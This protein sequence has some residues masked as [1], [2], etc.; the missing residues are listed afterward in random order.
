MRNRSPSSADV[1]FV[2]KRA[3]LS[4]LMLEVPSVRGIMVTCVSSM[5]SRASAT[6]AMASGSGYSSGICRSSVFMARRE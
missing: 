3:L 5:R 1:T 4:P 2:M 6:S